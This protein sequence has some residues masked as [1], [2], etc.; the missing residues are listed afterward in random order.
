MRLGICAALEVGTTLHARSFLRGVYLAS[1]LFENVRR[2][3]HVYFDDNANADGGRAAAKLFIDEKVDA[4]IGHF[5][6]ESAAAVVESYAQA[7]IALI[8]PASTCAALTEDGSTTFRVCASDRVLAQ[9]LLAFSERQGLRRLALF[10]DESLHG[11]QQLH[12]IKAAPKLSTVLVDDAAHADALVFCGRLKASHQF[13]RGQRA[14][15]CQLPLFFTD[16]AASPALVGGVS[17]LGTVYVVSFPVACDLPEAQSVD[18]AY[19]RIFGEQAPVYAIETLAAFALVDQ[20]VQQPEGLLDALRFQHFSTPTGPISFTNG[21]ND[22]ARV[23][24]WV[25]ADKR[26]HERRLLC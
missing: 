16:D 18:R 1:H 14:A 4:V 12:E 9:Q 2:A 26:V 17:Q 6:S 11:Q 5:A 24:L 20:A 3:R 25:Y 10:A 15:G 23:S 7:G 21:E 22:R 19:Q 8:L 13:L